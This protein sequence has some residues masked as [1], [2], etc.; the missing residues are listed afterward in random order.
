M[1]NDKDPIQ[2]AI[3]A[4]D[5]ALDSHGVN[6]S[7]YIRASLKQLRALQ[8]Q[9]A[10]A[11]GAGELTYAE[12][13]DANKRRQKD[14]KSEY[15]SLAEWM[16]ALTGEVGEAANVIKKVFRGDMTLDDAREKLG[17]EFADINTYLT[18]IAD[19]AGVDLAAVSIEKFNEVSRRPEVNSDVFIHVRPKE[20]LPSD[21]QAALDWVEKYLQSAFGK[22]EGQ[23]PIMQTI[24]AA[25]TAP[26]PVAD[27]GGLKREVKD[28][29]L[30][31]NDWKK[32]GRLKEREAARWSLVETIKFLHATGRLTTSADV[33]DLKD[34]VLDLDEEVS[35]RQRQ[36][37]ND[38]RH[39]IP[40]IGQSGSRAQIKHAPTI[41]KVKGK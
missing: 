34:A 26:Q 18:I 25:L 40:N 27:L 13:L 3:D 24:R 7:K 11:H 33:Q 8:S 29:I 2:L 37:E 6:T 5:A 14:W 39:V 15:W 12:F 35:R 1:T 32:E 4:L 31:R 30:S 19:K 9:P 22:I 28:E 17:K 23:R 21:K 20:P 16:T 38:L 10:A 41:A 36:I